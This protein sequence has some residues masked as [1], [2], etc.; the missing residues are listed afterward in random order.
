MSSINVSTVT[1]LY[2][3]VNDVNNAGKRIILAAG[4]YELRH[5]NPEVAAGTGGRLELQKDM[6][7]QGVQ[8]HPEKVIIDT[9]QLP[10]ASFS[11][12]QNFP[13]RRTGAIRMGK[14]ANSI[15]WLKVIGN[16]NPQPLSVIDTDLIWQGVSSVRI[17]H[18]IITGGRIGIDIRN[19]GDAS[20]NRVIEA[21]I[22]DNELV[23]NLVSDPGTQQGQGI[24][25]QNANGARNAIIR[26]KL[27][28]NNIHNNIIGMRVFNNNGNANTRTDK[29]SIT[30]QSHAD[31]FDENKL[32]IYMVAGSNRGANSTVNDNFL[33]FEAH[34]SSIQNNKGISPDPITLPYGIYLTGGS[35]SLASSDASGN[36]LKMKLTGCKISGNENKDIIAFGAFST[37]ATPAGTNN[38]VEI[39]LI[40]VSNTATLAITPSSPSE[41]TGTNKVKII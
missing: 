20:V 8:G 4:N 28:G 32:G 22:I 9:S 30:I 26:A 31:K 14:G 36:K 10:D 5:D 34:G 21:E 29:A 6:E 12:P 17:A 39:E 23:D 18:T 15:E 11:P 37:S 35:G 27:N 2:K 19:V 33:D 1:E 13:A 40:G 3:A 16:P 38:L 41:P 24:V 25:L 7:L